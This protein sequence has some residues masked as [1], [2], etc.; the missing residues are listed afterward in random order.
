[1]PR[2]VNNITVI[3]YW[4]HEC[5]EKSIKVDNIRVIMYW[6]H[7]CQEKSIVPIPCSKFYMINW[8][9]EILFACV[10]KTNVKA[11]SKHV[12]LKSIYGVIY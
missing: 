3:M 9:V 12:P 7:E 2:K 10:E 5:Q 4:V 11:H 6:V 1:M 8:L